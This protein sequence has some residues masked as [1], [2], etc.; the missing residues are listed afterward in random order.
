MS[1]LSSGIPR[2][3]GITSG[4]PRLTGIIGHQL[5]QWICDNHPQ[6]HEQIPWDWVKNEF[7]SL[8]FDKETE[9]ASINLLKKQMIALFANPT[10]LWIISKH[11]KERNEYELLVKHQNTLVTRIIDR[12][13]EHDN[14]LWIIDFKTGKDEFIAQIKH[15]QQLNEYAFHL[16]SLTDLPIHCGVFYLANTHWVSWQYQIFEPVSG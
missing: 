15:Q 9:E 10:G 12:T 2:L 4:I 16:A 8:G 3:T 1:G 11:D 13:F 7:K 5:L 14:K 6:N